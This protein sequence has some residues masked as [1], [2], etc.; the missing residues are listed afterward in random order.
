V[1]MY[2]SGTTGTPKAVLLTHG[3]IFAESAGFQ[4]AMRVTNREVALSL[5]PLYHAYSQV[6]NLW[7]A[8]VIGARVVYITEL[9][10]SEIERGLREGG[11]TALVGVPH[12]WRLFHK[13]IFD[14]VARRP[15]AVRWAFRAMRGFNGWL[16]DW[17]G[18][19]AGRLFFKLVHDSFGGRLRLAVSAGAS[20]DARVARDFHCLGFTILQGHGLCETAGA[21][22]IT[23]FED[24]RVGSVGTP[25]DGLEEIIHVPFAS[26]ISR[27]IPSMC[28]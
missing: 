28:G 26:F 1:L 22:T 20:V 13:K 24:D 19:N 10:S 7:V 2:T 5:L 16:R 9:S 25:L 27:K 4:K 17:L 6:V 18:F 11:A 3:N 21:A 12:L 8:T 14:A 23:R 15:L